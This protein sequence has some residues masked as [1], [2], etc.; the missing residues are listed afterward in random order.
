VDCQ[1]SRG[2]CNFEV[3]SLAPYIFVLACVRLYS[4]PI[5]LGYWNIHHSLHSLVCVYISSALR[6]AVEVVEVSGKR[7]YRGRACEK[8]R[9]VDKLK[10]ITRG[11]ANAYVP[12]IIQNWRQQL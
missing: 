6:K 3:I 1:I 7:E 11:V 10:L 5:N 8:H 9:L 12:I 2:R 4:S